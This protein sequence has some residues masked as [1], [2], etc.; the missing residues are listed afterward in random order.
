MNNTFL[1]E[2]NSHFIL[3]KDHLKDEH[4]NNIIIFDMWNHIERFIFYS[5]QWENGDVKPVQQYCRIA[6]LYLHKESDL[7]HIYTCFVNHSYILFG[8]SD[9]GDL[10]ILHI[11]HLWSTK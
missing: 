4:E 6:T 11:Y 7:S 8:I 5:F 3:S 9:Y 2:F 1:V 10:V